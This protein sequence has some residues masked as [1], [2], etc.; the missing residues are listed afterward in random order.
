MRLPLPPLLIVTDRKQGRG[1]LENIVAAALAAGARWV[2]LREK[3]LC[4]EEQIELAQR[5]RP[6]A[7]RVGARLTMHGDPACARRAGADGVHLSAGADAAAARALLGEQ[8]LIGLSMHAGDELAA[9][10]IASLDYLLAGPAFAT[11]SK[12]G[13][14]PV[15]GVSGVASLAAKLPLPLVA[16]GGIG[17]DNAAALMKAGAAGVAVM[18]GVMRSERPAQ[19]VGALIDA[20]GPH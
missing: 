3:D 14:G 11:A 20:L 8:A 5:L 4:A 15:L 12:P 2:S 7:R 13:Y 1:P 17:R 18:G 6:L 10:D 19:E 9:R 16:I